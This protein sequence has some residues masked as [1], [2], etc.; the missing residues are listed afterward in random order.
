MEDRSTER[1]MSMLNSKDREMVILGMI[2]CLHLGEEWCRR[3]IPYF[4]PGIVG[5]SERI[6]MDVGIGKTEVYV[7]NELGIRVSPT[8]KLD[9][10]MLC[11]F[12]CQT[13]S[14]DY[15]ILN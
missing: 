1:I 7:K 15:I 10:R 8:S 3:N 11:D 4:G 5:M 2:G 14:Y 9:V 13:D 6:M 12:Q